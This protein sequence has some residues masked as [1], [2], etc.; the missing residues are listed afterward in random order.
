MERA[1]KGTNVHYLKNVIIFQKDVFHTE[2]FQHTMQEQ[3]IPLQIIK[4][5]N[6]SAEEIQQE[7]EEKYQQWKMEKDN[8]IT[9]MLVI[10]DDGA[11][12]KWMYENQIPLIALEHKY[13]DSEKD[14]EKREEI[15]W[16]MPYVLQEINDINVIYLEKIYRRFTGIPWDILETNRCRLREITVED[17]PRIAEIYQ[18]P[19]VKKHMEPLYEPLER[20]V[21]Y[22][23]DYIKNVYGFYEYGTWIIIEKSSGEIIGR[24]GLENYG[25]SVDKEEVE[26]IELGYLIE[27]AYQGKGY[28]YEVCSAILE[29]AKEELH[30]HSIWARI[31]AD[32]KVS[33]ELCRKLG[34]SYVNQYDGDMLL[35]IKKI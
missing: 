26:Q 25:R 23:E 10:S 29:Y 18:T 8:Q 2:M 16:K 9:N 4:T 24:A 3:K 20:E 32:N 22:V 28:A 11:V 13:M 34:F 14:S 19:S 15:F 7:L 31:S 5:E 12:C 6:L 30:M 17:V 27:D 35:F 21:A 1:V 33:I